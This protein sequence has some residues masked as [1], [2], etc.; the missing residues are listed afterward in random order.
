MKKLIR[1]A[2]IIFVLILMILTVLFASYNI[3]EHACEHTICIQCE[4]LRCVGDLI[5]LLLICLIILVVMP[6]I[7]FLLS[8]ILTRYR[9]AP[10]TPIKLRDKL[11]D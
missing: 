8:Y 9:V 1:S 7:V 11:S 10:V 4:H 3:H 2:I 6:L 5:L